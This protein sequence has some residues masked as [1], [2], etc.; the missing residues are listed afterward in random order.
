MG[1]MVEYEQVGY[2]GSTVVTTTARTYGSWR[3]I[4]ILADAVFDEY[5]DANMDGAITGVTV[6]Q[7]TDLY[8][9]I[10]A[11]KLTSGSVIAYA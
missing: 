1:N 5:T 11:F 7:G 8:G 10:S 9:A 2:E 3:K 4:H 6:K